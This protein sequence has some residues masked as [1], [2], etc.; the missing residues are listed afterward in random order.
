[1]DGVILGY[2]ELVDT[3]EVRVRIDTGEGERVLKVN[4]LDFRALERGILEQTGGD[5]LIGHGVQFDHDDGSD[6]VET[7]RAEALDA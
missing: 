2:V 1:M 3:N 6:V 7:V 4:A 5:S